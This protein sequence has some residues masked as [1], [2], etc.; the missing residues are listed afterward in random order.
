MPEFHTKRRDPLLNAEP[1]IKQYQNLHDD[2]IYAKNL[3]ANHLG[4]MGYREDGWR[5]WHWMIAYS[6][7]CLVMLDYSRGEPIQKIAAAFPAMLEANEGSHLPHPPHE[8]EPFRLAERDTYP[9]ILSLFTF[10]KLLRHDA[11]VP[12]VAA[13]IDVAREHNRGQ[14][15]L[16]ETILQKL[17]LPNEPTNV[18]LK[19][20]KAHAILLEVIEAPAEK[21]PKLML[22]FLKKWYP[23]MKGV[24]WHN[25]HARLPLSFIGYWCWEAALVTY[26]WDIDDTSYRDMPFYPKD[27]VDWA[28][29]K[30]TISDIPASTQAGL[31]CPQSG[32]W[33][34]PAK[35]DSRA[36][37]NQGEVMPDFPGNDYGTVFWQWDADQRNPTL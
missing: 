35:A 5:A 9:Y 19:H 18:T 11:L 14:D 36:F 28:R 7:W 30:A 32:W 2:V 16:Y 1:C 8:I 6:K 23:S 34:T 15:K 33:F 27:L 12:R 29:Q 3:L 37:F 13:L 31:P 4:D 26:L 22:S 25:T 20:F 17:G 24:I 10:A 21:H